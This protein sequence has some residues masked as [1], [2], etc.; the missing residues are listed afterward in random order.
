M[1]GLSIHIRLANVEDIEL[2]LSFISQKAEFDR[3]LNV[4][5]TNAL[6][7]TTDKLRQTLFCN[8]PLAHLLFAEVDGI[9]V[10][11]ALFFYTYSS[12][13]AQPNIWLG[14]LFV[15]PQMRSKGIG[16]ALLAHLAQIAQEKNCGRLEWTVATNNTRGITFY[17]KLGAQILEN[18]RLCRVDKTS[19][20]RLADKQLEI[21]G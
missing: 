12:F 9:A 11:F 7:A 10:G 4:F 5:D 15:Q 16:T 2:I 3:C 17:K 13:L 19:I 18:T 14:D 8:P 20:T 21:I 1:S 6:E